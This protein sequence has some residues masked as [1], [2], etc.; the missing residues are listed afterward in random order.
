MDEARPRLR[1]ETPP[2]ALW[3]IAFLALSPFPA[4]ALMYCYGPAQ[5]EQG[6]LTILV[7]WSAIVLSFIAGVRWGLETREPQPRA[8]RLAF[9]ALCAAAALGVLLGR[10][11][12]PDAWMLALFVATFML[13]W[14]F[15][16]Q[17]PD[18]PRRYPTLST[19]LTASACVSLAFALEKAIRG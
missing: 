9:Y 2:L 17:A 10:G 7:T 14:L 18:T 12:A 6:S 8:V 13:Q 4:S 16:N 15:D 5:H 1:V 3:G 19:A 11:H